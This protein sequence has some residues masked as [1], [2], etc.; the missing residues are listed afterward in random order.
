MLGV[1]YAGSRRP[2][3]LD[4]AL[5]H[6]VHAS[7]GEK[8]WVAA[9]LVSPSS[10]AAVYVVIAV[11]VLL[12]LLARRRELAVLAVVGPALA[13]AVVELVGK[14]VVDR[15]L[16][17][18]LCYPSGHTAG[19]L[20]ALTVA[21]LGLAA[22]ARI[23]RRVLALVVWAV[24]SAAVMVGIVAMG[25]HYPTDTIAGLGVALG[26]VLPLAVLADV[27]TVRRVRPPALD[28]ALDAALGSS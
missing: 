2:S 21:M 11:T 25:Y 28:R 22:G 13:V 19:T 6:G 14:P 27:F 26:V 24:I 16:A 9:S 15:R 7:V 18:Y 4:V 23:V 3:R 20:S 5:I 17:G 10:P 1:R 12:A 8:D